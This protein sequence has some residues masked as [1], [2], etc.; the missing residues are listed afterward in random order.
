MWT[1]E[2][3]KQLTINSKIWICQR[4]LFI[5]TYWCISNNFDGF[6]FLSEILA[7]R[8]CYPQ[9]P[10]WNK[11]FDWLTDWQ[12]LTKPFPGFKIV[13]KTD[14]RSLEFSAA[15]AVFS[16]LGR[17]FR[18]FTLTE[19]L[20]QAITDSTSTIWNLGA[21]LQREK[22]NLRSGVPSSLILSLPVHWFLRSPEKKNA[23]S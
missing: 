20:A 21:S 23:W 15:C 7:E 17:F 9:I 4:F 14:R 12:S 1:S 22:I 8:F 16:L 2:L 3:D 11:V 10:K 6:C 18:L 19:S 13:G 5:Y